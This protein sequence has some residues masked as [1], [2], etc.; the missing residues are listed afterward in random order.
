MYFVCKCPLCKCR[1]VGQISID[2]LESSLFETEEEA[3]RYILENV[4]IK[5]G[6]SD[7]ELIL[8]IRAALKTS[9][10]DENLYNTVVKNLRSVFEAHI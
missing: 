5:T 6:P 1:I 4:V 9:I 3:K 2:G 10:T 8:N 7:D